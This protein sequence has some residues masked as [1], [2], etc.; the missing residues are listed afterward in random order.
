[1]VGVPGSSDVELDL[2]LESVL[3][4]VLVSGWA[5]ARFTGECG[6]CLTPVEGDLDVEVLELYVYPESDA[7]ED[8]A[9]RL[10]GSLLDLAPVLH[11]ALLL[12]LPRQPLCRED[13]PGLCPECGA[14]LAEEP[15]H[16]HERTDPRWAA[17]VALHTEP[18][19]QRAAPP[20]PPT[21]SPQSAQKES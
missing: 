11:D 4:G 21:E 18:Q 2:R 17:L 3:E 6:R 5:R 16:G 9:A 13:C 7:E 10:Q 15:E 20:A 14:R 12:G 1:V 19:A 8:E